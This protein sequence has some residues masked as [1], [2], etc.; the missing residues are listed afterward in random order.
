MGIR[1]TSKIVLYALICLLILL[2]WTAPCLAATKCNNL[3]FSPS[4][5]DE[6][7]ATYIN[8]LTKNINSNSDTTGFKIVSTTTTPDSINYCWSSE[9]AD[10][11]DLTKSY[12]SLFFVL[13]QWVAFNFVM[14][15]MT[16]IFYMGL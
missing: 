14:L 15:A 2:I 9:T 3:Y 16:K 11:T 1:Y 8:A 4:L 5:D 7:G 6:I 10:S 13:F 12:L